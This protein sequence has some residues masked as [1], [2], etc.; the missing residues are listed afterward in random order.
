MSEPFKKIYKILIVEDE[1]PFLK[2]L[3]ITLREAGF[4]TKTALN[5]RMALKILKQERF[6]A[7]LLDIVMPEENGFEVLSQMRRVKDAPCIIVTSNLGHPDD[8]A[9]AKK[10]GAKDYFIK[11]V[12]LPNI[13][14]H[15][16]GVL[17]NKESE[18]QKRDSDNN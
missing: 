7:V 10:L 18:F 11:A 6:D 14:N 13:V 8:I 4:E 12:H 17:E 15:L 3:D 2:D 9:E 5:G 1:G 16:R